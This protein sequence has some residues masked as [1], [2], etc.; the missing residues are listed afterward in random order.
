[1]GRTREVLKELGQATVNEDILVQA[2]QQ[3]L[4]DGV[5]EYLAS[6]GLT[7]AVGFVITLKNGET[8]TILSDENPRNDTPMD[9][10]ENIEVKQSAKAGGLDVLLG[11]LLSIE[12]LF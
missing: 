10:V 9:Q 8:F 2:G 7:E 4:R 12:L 5:K 6:K 3:V 11:N 1:M